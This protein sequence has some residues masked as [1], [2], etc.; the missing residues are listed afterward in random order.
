MAEPPRSR[1]LRHQLRLAETQRHALCSAPAE[2]EMSRTFL[3]ENHSI[4][5]RFPKKED[6]LRRASP[7]Q[8]SIKVGAHFARIKI[9]DRCSPKDQD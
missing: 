8:D 4:L 6:Q 5:S 3:R 7:F 1:R 9:G 2:F